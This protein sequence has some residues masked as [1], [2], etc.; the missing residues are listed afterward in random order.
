MTAWMGLMNLANKLKGSVPRLTPMWIFAIFAA[1]VL[2]CVPLRLYQTIRLIE[3][4]TGFFTQGNHITV[5][6]LY[7]V[8]GIAAVLILILSYL[9]IGARTPM[10]G[11]GRS[12]TLCVMAAVM[13]VAF[14]ADGIGTVYTLVNSAVE[15]SGTLGASG[16]ARYTVMQLVTEGAQILFS[17]ISCTYFS[18]L[19][20]SWNG[21]GS[22]ALYAVLA[23]AP[24]FWAIA[25]AV[26]RFIRMI[27]FKN[28]SDL[29]LELFM[30]AF[31]MIFFLA[32]A[33]VNSKVERAGVQWQ[34]YGCG[35][36]TALLAAVVSIPRLVMLVC[37]M[38]DRIADGY[39]LNPCDLAAPFFIVIYLL[40]ASSYRREQPA[41][42]QAGTADG[43]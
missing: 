28:V 39:P 4:E 16:T 9:G 42:P 34:V 2:S 27:N 7:T 36:V 33:R 10:P 13:A 24:V 3:P 38:G 8:A 32:F 21:K 37:G 19:A 23:V 6:L 40:V 12:R 26:N 22:A 25:R 15:Y 17:V 35:L 30:L 31:M 18:C 43:C 11:E 14:L 5:T 1:A 20:F 41:A 29:L